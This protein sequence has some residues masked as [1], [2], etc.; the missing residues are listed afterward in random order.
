MLGWMRKQSLVKPAHGLNTD[1]EEGIIAEIVSEARE[2]RVYF[3][4]TWWPARSLKP[5]RLNPG[6]AVRVIGRDGLT[7]FIEPLAVP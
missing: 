4:G 2:W 5:L 7:L 1:R 6:D 3:I